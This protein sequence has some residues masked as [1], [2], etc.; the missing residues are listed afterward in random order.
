MIYAFDGLRLSGNSLGE[1]ETD[2]SSRKTTMTPRFRSAIVALSLGLGGC[3]SYPG[4][5]DGVV[6]SDGSYYS[7]AAGAYGDYYYAPS[8]SAYPNYM[9][10][11]Y[12]YPY[13][14]YD[15]YCSARYRYCAP[16]WYYGY[17]VP[18]SYYYPY[19]YPSSGYRIAP[20]SSSSGQTTYPAP[21]NAGATGAAR[22]G[23][24]RR[25][26]PE[27]AP[28][29]PYPSNANPVPAVAPG[30]ARQSIRAGAEFRRNKGAAP[31]EP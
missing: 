6:Y 9:Y 14:Y 20:P 10:Y 4:E 30:G 23:R 22:Y 11:G 1:A 5:R 26:A 25:L 12:P 29:T 31:R 7:P 8:A 24:S 21:T 18:Y 16:G 15:P 17:G 2:F 13:S 3:A 28:S 27:P 19:R